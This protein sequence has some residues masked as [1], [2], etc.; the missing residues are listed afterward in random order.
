MKVVVTVPDEY[1]GNVTGDIASRRGM[2]I[3]TEIA[4]W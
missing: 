4:A 1:L 3:D 2:I